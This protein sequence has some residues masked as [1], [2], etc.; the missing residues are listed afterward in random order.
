MRLLCVDS[1][2]FAIYHDATKRPKYV[3]ASHRWFDD[4]EAT[5]GDIQKRQN[6]KK[7]G[8]AKVEAFARYIRDNIP[9]VKWL[10]IDTCC[11]NKDSAA[12]LSEAI[13]LMFRWYREAELCLAYLADIKAVEDKTGFQQSEWFRRGWTLQ[14]L[15]APRAVVFVTEAWQVVGNKGASSSGRNIAHQK[16]KWIED[17][18]TTREEDMSYALYGIFDITLGANYGEGLEGA[19]RRLMAAIN[20]RYNAAAQQAEHYRKIVDW[21][22]PS[23][24]WTNHHSARQRHEPD[25]GSWLLKCNQYLRWRADEIKHLW[26]FGKAGCGTTVLCSTAIEDIQA[27][28]DTEH[29]LGL[30]VFYFS[31][32]D[33]QRQSFEDLLRSLVAQVAWKEPGLSMLQQK[34]EKPNRSVL[35]GDDLERVLLSSISSYDKFFLVLDALDESPENGETRQTVLERVERLTQTASNIKILAT[36]RELRDV[37]ESV[38]TLGAE[39]IS[40]ATSAVDADIRKYVATQLSR[41]RRFARL[42]VKTTGLIEESI[43]SRADG[44]YDF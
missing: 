36:S 5:F 23:D 22:S 21:L 13:N 4:A 16:L 29:N 35:E 44:M 31:F 10:W 32:S 25:T 43:S 14:E 19:R 1:L 40:V 15:L 24:P 28:C 30:A 17:R 7:R 8:Y 3:I 39:P 12:E 37:R 6:T 34:Y 33:H 9:L 42:D 41:D 26:V 2:T 11:I 27:Y 38:E 20:Q 18:K